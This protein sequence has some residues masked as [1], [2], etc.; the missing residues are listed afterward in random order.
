MVL[1]K[2]NLSDFSNYITDP[3]NGKGAP[4]VLYGQAFFNADDFLRNFSENPYLMNF[5]PGIHPS[6]L[7][8]AIMEMRTIP[9]KNVKGIALN[10]PFD[11]YSYK[12]LKG[13]FTF[14]SQ[15]K[16]KFYPLMP[17]DYVKQNYYKFYKE[18]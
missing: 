5:V 1:T 9:G 4:K 6:R 7:R 11:Q 3:R 16:T 2:Y 8:D 10:C 13:G 18:M 12:Q 15:G 17:I 14:A